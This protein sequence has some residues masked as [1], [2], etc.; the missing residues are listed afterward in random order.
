MLKTGNPLHKWYI[1]VLSVFSNVFIPILR[2]VFSKSY[3][4]ACD[5]VLLHNSSIKM[6]LIHKC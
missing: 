3:H 4:I 5:C 2:S 6:S 1:N